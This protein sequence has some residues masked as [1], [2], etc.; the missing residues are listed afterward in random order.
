MK[1]DTG[2]AE[3]KLWLLPVL[4]K[5]SRERNNKRG[6]GG[7]REREGRRKPQRKRRG[8]PSGMAQTIMD[9]SVIPGAGAEENRNVIG[10]EDIGGA[11]RK[12]VEKGNWSLRTRLSK[13]GEDYASKSGSS[14]RKDHSKSSF[15]GERLKKITK[16]KKRKKNDRNL[17]SCKALVLLWGE[18]FFTFRGQEEGEGRGFGVFRAWGEPARFMPANV[19]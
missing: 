17:V 1:S 13:R 14:R 8:E 11:R 18:R 4:E 19:H 10:G 2:K 7:E 16:T 3:L 9:T 12:T 5:S 15:R 6:A